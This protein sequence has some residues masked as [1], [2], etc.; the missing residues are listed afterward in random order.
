M[1]RQLVIGNWKMN[2]D[3]ASNTALLSALIEGL[4][5][6]DASAAAIAVCVPSVYLSAVKA[7]VLSS[8]IKV[9]AQNLSQHGQGAYTGEV[10][11]N[12]L[13]DLNTD[14]ALVGHSERRSLFGE[15]SEVVAEKFAAA[16]DSG[17]T[18]ILCVGETLEE[19]E[20]GKTLSVVSAQLKA[21]IDRVALNEETDFIIAY[22]PVWAI[23]T[24]LTATPEQAQDVHRNIRELL[25]GSVDKACADRVAILYGGS[26]STASAQALFA[27]ADIDGGLVGG[28]SLQAEDFLAIWH[29]ASNS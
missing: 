2:G 21:V 15:S 16:L 9:G 25:A 8:P 6:T 5:E 22:E 29:A 19:R 26:V 18:P 27:Q 23:G 17:L 14:Y 11:A 13:T 20:T 12:M 10:S 28:A 7:Q 1:R 24:G 4:G 3:G